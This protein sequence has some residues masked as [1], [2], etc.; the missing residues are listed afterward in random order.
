VE[1]YNCLN[2][3]LYKGAS[4]HRVRRS[5]SLTKGLED[6]SFW[7][8]KEGNG[9]VLEWAAIHDQQ[10]VF[11]RLLNDPKVDKVQP[12]TYGVTLLHRL[13]GQGKADLMKPLIS[14]LRDLTIDPFVP[15]QARLTP[16]HF[17]A[18]MGRIEAT[19]LLINEGAD[20][21]ANDHHGNKPLHLAAVSGSFSVFPCLI[22]GGAQPNA[23]TRL[24]WKAIDMASVTHHTHAVAELLSFGSNPISWQRKKYGINE[25]VR[26]SPCPAEYCFNNLESA[27]QH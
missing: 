2:N 17:A 26:L 1:L 27:F 5:K 6:V 8:D 10:T 15:D 18:G 24:G 9:S 23:E 13:A 19:A 4:D 14:K 11:L 12:D 3:L 21:N 16:L 22:Q 25:Y 7:F 20:V